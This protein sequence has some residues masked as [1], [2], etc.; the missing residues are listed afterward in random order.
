MRAGVGPSSSKL[1]SL[2]F[3]GR[4][5]RLVGKY[6]CADGGVTIVSKI[7]VKHSGWDIWGKNLNRTH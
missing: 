1:D 6:E 5:Q 7:W 4:A 2:M 3:M